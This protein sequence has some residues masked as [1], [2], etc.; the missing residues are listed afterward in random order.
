MQWSTL[1]K[2]FSS[3][4]ENTCDQ[5]STC[6]ETVLRFQIS[7]TERF[8]NSICLASMENCNKR[9][10]M[11]VS[12]VFNTREH[13]DSRRVLWRRGFP[14]F[15]KP[16]FSESV[17]SEI[18]K[19]KS[20]CFFSKFRKFCADS[21]NTSKIREDVFHC[22]DNGSGTRCGHFFHLT[23]K[24]HLMGSQRVTKKSYD[25]RSH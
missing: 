19:L 10:A 24:T 21:E 12:A 15:K 5:H 14:A 23:T 13:L 17:T 2:F 8:S 20:W 11:V 9:A 6:Y 25:F 1:P 22:R 4:D 16:Y 7:L 3:N 18:F